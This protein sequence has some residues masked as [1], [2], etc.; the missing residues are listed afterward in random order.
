[1][2]IVKTQIKPSKIHGIGLFAAEFISKGTLIWKYQSYLDQTIDDSKFK[3]LPKR[4]QEF[5]LKY[6]SYNI[7]WGGHILCGDDAR[8]TNHSS[9]P[10]TISNDKFSTIAIR[11]IQ[12]GEEITE[13]YRTIDDLAHKETW[14]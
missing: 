7:G 14:I 4:A 13:N 9:D 5:L 12:I 3:L 6:A 8:F 2:L 11:D 10:N 1:M